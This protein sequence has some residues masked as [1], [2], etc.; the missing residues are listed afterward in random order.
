MTDFQTIAESILPFEHGED[1]QVAIWK[2]LKH[3]EIVSAL[4]DA[5]ISGHQD[6]LRDQKDWRA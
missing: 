3:R 2:T 5:W 1:V 4:E 6:G